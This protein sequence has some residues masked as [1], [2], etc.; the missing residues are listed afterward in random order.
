MQ[1]H[2][3]TR[4]SIVLL[5]ALGMAG[6]SADDA[7]DEQNRVD[8]ETVITDPAGV[9]NDLDDDSDVLGDVMDDG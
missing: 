1:R 2:V 5:V 6:C 7:N 9:A 3:P 8:D 4:A